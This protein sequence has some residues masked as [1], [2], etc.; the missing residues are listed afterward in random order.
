MSGSPV[1]DG[2]VSQ[3]PRGQPAGS[4][5]TLLPLPGSTCRPP[6][7]SSSCLCLLREFL[8]LANRVSFHFH[9]ARGYQPAWFTV[10]P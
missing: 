4:L 6:A 8:Q 2:P 5:P 3:G 10:S 7:M 9:S 1:E